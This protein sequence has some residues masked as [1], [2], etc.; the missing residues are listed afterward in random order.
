[1]G[2]INPEEI[3]PCYKLPVE[4]KVEE[5]N[6]LIQASK[7]EIEK[8]DKSIEDVIGKIDENEKEALLAYIANK[9]SINDSKLQLT[10]MQ[11]NIEKMSFENTIFELKT[12]MNIYKAATILEGI[13][14]ICGVVASFI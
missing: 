11:F 9:T 12:N 10:Q 13:L 1:M 14:I 7:E 6:K 8:L 4:D 2:K 3:Q 5:L